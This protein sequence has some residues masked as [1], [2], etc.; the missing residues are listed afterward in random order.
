MDHGA[1][2][3]DLTDA[4]I[5]LV[6]TEGLAAVTIRRLAD[7]MRLS[8]STLTSHLTS[9][10]RMLHLI[11]CNLGDRVIDLVDRCTRYRGLPGLIPDDD[12]LPV[13]RTW[14][15]MVELTRTDV[16]TGTAVTA[17]E[18]DLAAFVRSVQRPS[19][20]PLVVDAV[21]ASARGL[22]TAMCATADPMTGDHARAVLVR[23]TDAMVP[24]TTES[25]S[26]F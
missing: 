21:A 13:V 11:T 7:V 16:G 22:W 18:R 19:R 8:P 23:V 10:R 12:D 3:A 6:T 5:H 17:F 24:Q 25:G 1:R 20:E 4:T 15:A 9:R 14:L 26:S 2:V